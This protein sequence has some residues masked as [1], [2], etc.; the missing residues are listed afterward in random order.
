MLRRT[1]RALALLAVVVAGLVAVTPSTS[2]A[3]GPDAV[4]W[5]SRQLPFQDPS[6]GDD[7][8]TGQSAG[9]PVRFGAP[10]Q[11]PPLPVP[12]TAPGS[13]PVTTPPLPVQPPELPPPPITTPSPG[14]GQPNPTV[15]DGGLWVANDATGA[16]AVS[17]IRF[18]GDI[19]AAELTLTFA[20]GSTVFGPVVV[21]PIV[22]DWAPGPA[23]AWN[24]RPAED[25]G[26]FELT[27][28]LSPDATQL[29]FSIPDGFNE[30]GERVLDLAVRPR[31]GAGE[32]FDLY[33]EAPG[34]DSLEVLTSQTV[35]PSQP[36]PADPDPL[37][38]P[39]TVPAPVLQDQ[40]F[41]PPPPPAT[42]P[43]TSPEESATPVVE[44]G[45]GNGPLPQPV[46]ELLEPF[47]ESRA[48]R[49][50]AV[51]LLLGM[52][53]GLWY[54]G[55][56]QVR[57]PRLLGALGGGAD[58]AAAPAVPVD[59]GRGIGRFRRERTGPPTRF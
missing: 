29:V 28:R 4:G 55:G 8:V 41:A 22:S 47:T 39:T 34:P 12:T 30:F 46:A 45:G 7:S 54:L 16:R 27:G 48:S 6:R 10:A 2:S 25:C 19:G 37:S 59:Q 3:A 42:T 50:L 5:W 38:L 13:G 57:Q 21:C 32:T 11:V 43:T 53:L 33:F 17:A 20:P 51:L 49:I 56:Q 31:P 14:E 40:G 36:E 1:L 18:R 24:D 52:G 15:P 35:P 44:I 58:A 9:A 26:R 23:G